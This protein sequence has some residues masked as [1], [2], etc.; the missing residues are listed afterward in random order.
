MLPKGEPMPERD[1]LS[2]PERII[3][4]ALVLRWPDLDTSAVA[5]AAE[6]FAALRSAGIPVGWPDV[7][8]RLLTDEAVDAASWVETFQ[9]GRC[10]SE[11][12][13]AVL[14]AAIDHAEQAVQ[15]DRRY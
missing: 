11:M 13:R 7:R 14:A 6:A 4:K 2:S 9:H 1:H 15:D 3:A 8:E 12:A 5:I 10:G